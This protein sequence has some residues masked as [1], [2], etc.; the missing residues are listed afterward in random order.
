[1]GITSSSYTILSWMVVCVGHSSDRT[2][3]T[4]LEEQQLKTLIYRPLGELGFEREAYR[5]SFFNNMSFWNLLYDAYHE[6]TVGCRGWDIPVAIVR[7]ADGTDAVA[8]YDPTDDYIR[9][10]IRIGFNDRMP[11]MMTMP[12]YTKVWTG[13]D[14]MVLEHEGCLRFDPRKHGGEGGF[15][16][17]I[18]YSHW[19]G[20]QEER[21]YLLTNIGTESRIL[22]DV[23]ESVW[24]DTYA[25]PEFDPENDLVLN[26][27]TSYQPHFVFVVNG[28]KIMTELTAEGVPSLEWDG[29]L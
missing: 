26:N 25:F 7:L 8:V 11:S 18:Q 10:P 6:A 19:G 22:L 15:V 4:Y 13:L 29:E 27:G 2:G 17:N 1:M 21:M 14:K 3:R 5:G 9:H 28:R 24:R 23:S 16:L 12:V 20:F